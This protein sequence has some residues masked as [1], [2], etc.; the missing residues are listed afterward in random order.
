MLHSVVFCSSASADFGP[1]QE[2]NHNISVAFCSSLSVYWMAGGTQRRLIDNVNTIRCASAVLCLLRRWAQQN[3]STVCRAGPPARYTVG[4]DLK[5][6][7][8]SETGLWH[9]HSRSIPF[10]KQKGGFS[11][12][13]QT[14]R[15]SRDFC[16]VPD[17]C[18]IYMSGHIAS[19]KG[20]RLRQAA[21]LT[22]RAGGY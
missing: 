14:A 20:L 16:T 5:P 21:I 11:T 7:Y 9:Y 2:R 15:Q 22:E 19:P 12:Q 8:H 4:Q 17:A 3:T 10:S 6:N 1:Y 13:V 18:W